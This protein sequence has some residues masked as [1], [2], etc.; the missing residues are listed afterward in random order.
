MRLA[1][2][3]VSSILLLAWFLP[4][5]AFGQEKTSG[6]E[7]IPMILYGSLGARGTW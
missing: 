5:Q 2:F 4:A 7:G 3:Y 6:G 1:V